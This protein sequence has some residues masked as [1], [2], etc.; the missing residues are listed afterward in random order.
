MMVTAKELR[1]E[2]ELQNPTII[3]VVDRIELEDQISKNFQAFGFP[4]ITV[5]KNK[6][7]LR[8]LLA[9][10][11]RGLIITIIHKFAG[12]PKNINTRNNIILLIDEAHRSQE[13]D[14]RIDIEQLYR[15]HII[16]ASQ[17]PQSTRAGSDKAPSQHSATHQKTHTSTNTS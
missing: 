4:N 6:D 1:E 14:L 5:A 11:Y 10:D 15:M 3:A 2:A 13:G 12:M 17:G 9:S 7:H 8:E 16:S